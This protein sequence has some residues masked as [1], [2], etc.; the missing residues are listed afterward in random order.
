MP[1]PA[2]QRFRGQVAIVTGA[3]G[4]IGRAAAARLAAEGA[5]VVVADIDAVGAQQAAASLGEQ[6]LGVACDVAVAT[7]VERLVAAT[8]ER[9]GRLDA[10]VNNAAVGAFGATVESTDETT[11][12]RIVGVNLKSV[13]LVSRAAIPH[14]R[15]AG[16]GTI[17]NVASVHAHL[18]S[19]GVAP[20]AAAKGGV[21]ALTRTMALDLA[22][23]GIRV[24]AVSP[25]AVETPMLHSHADR[26]GLTLEQMGF[27]HDGRSIGR[28]AAP[29]EIAAVIAFLCSRDASF[30]TGSTVNA[31]G[32]L[33]ARF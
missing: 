25:G 28:I 31:D 23:D 9:F 1:E 16:G 27:A 14:L 18:T 20:Y 26:A 19:P 8:I 7:D 15:A 12:D 2:M 13:Y 11:W 17:V 3:A 33:T 29:E 21:L 10:L 32:G 24:V 22:E 30:V 5:A 6:A 4:G